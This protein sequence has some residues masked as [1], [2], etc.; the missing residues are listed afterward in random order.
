MLRPRRLYAVIPAKV[1]IGLEVI[2]RRSDGYHDLVT[3][4]QA[5]SLYDLFEWTETG[6]P[7][8]YVG[9]AGVARDADLVWRALASAPDLPGWT[10]R[11]RL[12]KRVPLAAG[13]GGGSADAALALR[14]AF[15]AVGD[16]ELSQRGAALGADVPF[17]VRGGTALATGTGAE[18]APIT[19]PRLWFVLVTPPIDI[20][21]KTRALYSGLEPGDFSDGAN[22]RDITTSLM[23]G[24][25]LPGTV[26]NAFSRQLLQYPVMRYAYD[27]LGQAGASLISVS[28]AGPTLY[29]LTASH[30]EAAGIAARLDEVEPG[31]G[32]V[33]V[34]CA[35]AGRGATPAIAALAARLRG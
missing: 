35:V 4:F 1:N 19:T 17:F 11:L 14:L 22:V 21:D 24:A 5:V 30:R 29:A 26:R 7:F 10:G 6:L 23:S 3:L 8:E 16:A 12:E 2:G 25:G 18:L 28:G 32:A 13:L 27:R 31:V 33:H 20:P 15:P 9:P 34:V